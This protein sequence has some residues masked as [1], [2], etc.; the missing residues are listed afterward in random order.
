MFEVS[1]VFLGGLS[2]IWEEEGLLNP[3]PLPSVGSLFPGLVSDTA[4][5]SSRDS[6]CFV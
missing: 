3:P 6:E 4:E 1:I 5:A 2:R